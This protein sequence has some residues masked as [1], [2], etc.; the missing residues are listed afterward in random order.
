MVAGT[1][2]FQT[3][4][5]DAV[6]V[7]DAA[8]TAN[9]SGLLTVYT[10]TNTNDSGTGSFRQALLDATSGSNTIDFAIPGS[11]VHTIPVYTT[12]PTIS[13]TLTINGMSQSGY[14]GTPLIQIFSEGTP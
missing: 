8:D 11:G 3:S 1:L 12:L 13:S 7:L 5:I 9:W 14:S 4:V 2:G 6:P 10:V